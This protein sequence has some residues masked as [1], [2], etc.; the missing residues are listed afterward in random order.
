MVTFPSKKPSKKPPAFWEKIYSSK[1]L[2]KLSETVTKTIEKTTEIA[3]KMFSWFTDLFKRAE[4]NATLNKLKNSL[5]GPFVGFLSWLEGFGKEE[6][7]EEEK[8]EEEVAEKPEEAKETKPKKPK[9]P[10]E[11]KKKLAAIKKQVEEDRIKD[12]FLACETYEECK[13]L[14]KQKGYIWDSATKNYISPKLHA[15]SLDE[16]LKEYRGIK[17]K[18][19]LMEQFEQADKT[20]YMS[21]GEH[22]KVSSAFRS[23]R[24]QW[25]LYRKKKPKGEVV[26]PPG[27]SFHLI[28]QAIDVENWKKAEPYLL[29]AGFVGGSKGIKGDP[30]HFSVGEMKA[31]LVA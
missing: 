17:L 26:A 27:D 21:I 8:P 18:A 24:K 1:S 30:W 11:T 4:K 14:L 7:E 13:E 12:N 20:M 25:E 19:S 5:M 16:P 31:K 28:G 10:K 15:D 3:K 29:A 9:K 6:K 22:I 2:D 23:N